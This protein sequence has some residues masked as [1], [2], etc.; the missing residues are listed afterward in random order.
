[1]AL[2]TVLFLL[3]PLLKLKTDLIQSQ[4]FGIGIWTE[5]WHHLMYTD[6]SA[7]SVHGTHTPTYTHSRSW[8]KGE[9]RGSSHSMLINLQWA[10]KNTGRNVRTACSY[11]LTNK[12]NWIE[13]KAH[14]EQ[15]FTQI[16]SFCVAE[17]LP[18]CLN[19]F[20]CKTSVSCTVIRPSLFALCS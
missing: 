5:P 7:F 4:M 16:I 9:I 14:L 18:T 13:S 8:P 11:N 1:M 17:L 20:I 15:T 12:E 2:F 19:T 6:W 10:K 3:K